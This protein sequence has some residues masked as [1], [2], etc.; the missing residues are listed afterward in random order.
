MLDRM[1]N[2]YV[3]EEEKRIPLVL[4]TPEQYRSVRGDAVPVPL[5]SP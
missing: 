3:T 4:P 2:G 1:L 5:V